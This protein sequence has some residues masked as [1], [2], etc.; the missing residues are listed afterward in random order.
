MYAES[1]HPGYRTTTEQVLSRTDIDVRGKTFLVTGAT[2]GLGEETARSLAK[3]GAKVIFSARDLAAA[4]KVVAQ[5]KAETPTAEVV[6]YKLD[7]S[8]LASV[9]A[10]AE[11]VKASGVQIS[12]LICN[13]GVMATPYNKTVDGFESQF[14]T[15]HVAHFLLTRLLI[16]N[17]INNAPSRV[18]V[19]SS[20]GHRRS[21]FTYYLSPVRFDDYNFEKGPYDSWEAYGQSKTAN[22]LFAYHL[23]KLYA[24]KGV[25][26]FS[27]HPG[28]VDTPLQRHMSKE[29]LAGFKDE[30]G[31]LA[32]FFKTVPQGAATQ[33]WA[34]TAP[35][36]TDKG[37]AYLVDVHVS[38]VLIEQ[39][40]DPAAAERLWALTEE[41]VKSHL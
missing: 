30:E 40:R 8:S 31:N 4:E 29:E 20:I 39:A 11:E 35:E 2:S 36:L 24:S 19:V 21:S 1:D 7:L 9:K 22:I 25:E 15:N 38:E 17:L 6:Y 34:A 26:A 10:F 28:P 23:N 16:D 18:I 3:H 12:A 27:L 32:S 14:G 33:V 5:I 13:A 37:G 41:L